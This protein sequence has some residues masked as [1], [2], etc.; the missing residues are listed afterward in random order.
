MNAFQTQVDR[1]SDGYQANRDDML[2]LV[3]Q[4][5]R[6]EARAEAL[7]EKRRDTFAQRGQLTPRERIARLLDPGMPFLDLYN[8]ANFLVEDANRETSVPGASMV[9]GIGF[10]SGVRC[11]V[12][13]DD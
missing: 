7:S 9:C 1:E 12:V 3:A 6:Y 8:L 4:L 13:A 11:L 5:R 10:V 2:G